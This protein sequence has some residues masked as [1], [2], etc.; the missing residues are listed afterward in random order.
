MFDRKVYVNLAAYNSIFND[1]QVTTTRD[2]GASEV[3]NTAKAKVYGLEWEVGVRPIDGLNLYSSGAYTNNKYLEL[4]ERAATALN[5]AEKLAM[6]SRWQAQFGGNYE[7]QLG[8]A[9]SLSLAA[10]YDYR[11]PYFVQ[12][13]LHP[14]SRIDDLNRVN[15]SITY[16][17]PSEKAE[18]YLQGSNLTKSEDWATSMNFMPGAF[19]TR[20]AANPRIIRLGFRYKY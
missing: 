17:T 8:N 14:I 2:D 5:N 3:I 18:I 7:F 1:L 6:I 4:D 12:V 20:Y 9:G 10:N 11:S 13:S 16:K 15:G 19:A